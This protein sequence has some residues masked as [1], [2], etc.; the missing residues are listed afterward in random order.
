MNILIDKLPYFVLVDG[1]DTKIRADFRTGILFEQLMKDCLISDDVKLELAINLYFPDVFIVNEREAIDRIL[2]F[3]NCGKDP[4]KNG[5]SKGYAKANIYDY[6]QDANY[7]YAAFMEQYGIDL[8]DIEF[9]HW[10]KF[11]SLFYSLNKD[12][13]MSKIMFY[14][15]VELSD[16]MSKDERKFYRDMKSL[17]ALDDMRSDD[18]KEQDF[19]DSLALLF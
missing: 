8:A 18:E 1:I 4:S 3:Y 5:R 7:I 13:L 17:Y 6:E 15:S 16:N 11:K 2:W 19:N 9:L 12:I 10:W 14:R